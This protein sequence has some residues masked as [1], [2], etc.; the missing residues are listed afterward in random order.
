MTNYKH[1]FR[2]ILEQSPNQFTSYKYLHNVVSQ[3]NFPDLPDIIAHLK[4]LK[5]FLLMKRRVRGLSSNEAVNDK[6]WQVFVTNAVRRFIIFVS[7]LNYNFG[8][9]TD[10]DEEKRYV[11]GSLN[12]TELNEYMQTLL[13]PLDVLMVWHTFMLN[14]RSFYDNFMR[15]DFYKFANIPFPFHLIN[16]AIDDQTFEFDPLARLK[17]GYFSLLKPF[18]LGNTPNQ[19]FDLMKYDISEFNMYEYFL[20]I[21]C[22]N[23]KFIIL[24][25]VPYSNIGN[26]GFADLNFAGITNTPCHCD[27]TRII[28]HTELRKRQMYSDSLSPTVFPGVYQHF[29]T[30]LSPNLIS[31]EV[32]N[33]QLQL[34]FDSEVRDSLSYTDITRV[35]SQLGC[36]SAIASTVFKGYLNMNLIHTSVSGPME[37]LE[38]SEDLVSAI[39][40]QD[41]FNDRIDR[42][43]WLRSPVLRETLEECTI[44]YERF[45]KLLTQFNHNTPLVATLDIDLIW[46][47]HQLSAHC[48][49]HD[50]LT[51]RLRKVVDYPDHCD[52]DSLTTENLFRLMFKEKYSIC[53]CWYCVC[54]RANSYAKLGKLLKLESE[55]SG[56]FHPSPCFIN[57]FAT[58]A[59]AGEST[60]LGS[61]WDV[62]V[63]EDMTSELGNPF[64][65][66]FM[67]D[68]TPN[69]GDVLEFEVLEDEYLWLGQPWESP[70]TKSL[71]QTKSLFETKSFETKSFETKSLFELRMV[72]SSADCV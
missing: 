57:D 19:V 66:D 35:V 23:C 15:N 55:A 36:T 29:S 13:P 68:V 41:S 50:C 16:A 62:E 51:S 54:V 67:E 38:I 32:I 49:F 37:I 58:V 69:L 44:R 17:F 5:A 2:N 6:N 34:M 11:A 64:E 48:Y 26:Y 60:P 12:D 22:P 56:K 7:C 39:L 28:S 53:F 9:P 21:A 72:M 61:P 63:V 3:L 10:T 47:T 24:H 25:N 1:D 40:K 42:L 27:F 14:P 59:E 18:I 71:F 46:R 31:C 70:E 65:V 43:D 20:D 33:R 45:Y 30:V 8:E 4:L 52:R